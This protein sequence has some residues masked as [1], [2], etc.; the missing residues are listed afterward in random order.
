MEV[1]RRHRSTRIAGKAGGAPVNDLLLNVP[2]SSMAKNSLFGSDM[3]E[4]R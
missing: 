2:G 4:T 1:S 3:I